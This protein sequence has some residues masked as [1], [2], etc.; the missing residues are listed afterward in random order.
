MR[1]AERIVMAEKIKELR[2]ERGLSRQQVA[3]ALDLSLTAIA[4]Y[5]QGYRIPRI[6]NL[7]DLAKFFKVS[8][9][10]LVG[11]TDERG[12]DVTVSVLKLMFPPPQKSHKKV[13]SQNFFPCFLLLHRHKKSP[14]NIT[15]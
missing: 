2:E 15:K 11:S 1:A 5:E 14:Q 7:Q 12:S 3:D 4:G 10:Y 13:T 8:I 9:D 6:E